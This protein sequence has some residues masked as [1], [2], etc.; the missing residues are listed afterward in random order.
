MSSSRLPLPLKSLMATIEK[1]IHLKTHWGDLLDPPIVMLSTPACAGTLTRHN[2][3][4]MRALA[5]HV[6]HLSRRLTTASLAQRPRSPSM[7]SC[8][9]AHLDKRA[10]LVWQHLS[11]FKATPQV[12]LSSVS[13]HRCRWFWA[14]A[15]SPACKPFV[16]W[17]DRGP[18]MSHLDPPPPG[19]VNG[20]AAPAPAGPSHYR[21]VHAVSESPMLIHKGFF[22]VLLTRIVTIYPA[23]KLI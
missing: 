4:P 8:S 6:S 21:Q 5:A 9:G 20:A 2:D 17:A 10:L 23:G 13:A 7:P 22:K 16:G 15:Q 1:V 11:P 19:Q 3:P 12:F 18:N 14:C